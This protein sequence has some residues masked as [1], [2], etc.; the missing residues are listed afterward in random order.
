MSG[1]SCGAV[2]DPPHVR[3][4]LEAGQ[5][6]RPHE[7]GQVLDDDVV[8]RLRPL[9]EPGE[10][11]RSVRTHSGVPRGAFFSKKTCPSTPSG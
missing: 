6:R 3:V 10:G 9:L 1:G 7:R 2:A 8:D 4:Q 11:S 5:V